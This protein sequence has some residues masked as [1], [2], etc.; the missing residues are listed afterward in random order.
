MKDNKNIWLWGVLTLLL[1]ITFFPLTDVGFVTGDDFVYSIWPVKNIIKDS[2]QFARG[3]GRFY[4]IFT[5]WIYKI[6][7]LIDSSFYYHSML[8]LPHISVVLLFVFLIKRIFKNETIGLLSGFIFCMF[9]QI[10]GGH[11]STAAYPF[12]FTFSFTILIG[13]LHF[14]LTY[15]ETDKYKYLLISAFIFAIATLFYE[16]YLV[17]YI[18]VFIMLI[19]R[20]HISDLK[21]KKSIFRFSKEIFPYFIFGITYIITYFVYFKIHSGQYQGNSFSSDLN[22]AIFFKTMGSLTLFS[23]PL[24]SLLDYKF[25]LIEYS[26]QD[27]QTINLFTL[28]FKQASLSAFIKGGL[29]LMVFYWIGIKTDFKIKKSFM[30]SV[31]LVSAIFIA[32]P[33]LPLALSKKYTTFIPTTYVTTYFAYFGVVTLCLILLLF[34]IVQSKRTK[35]I[36]YIIMT[37]LGIGLFIGTV[38]TQNVNEKVCEDLN[39]A[40]KRI[41]LMRSLFSANLINQNSPIYLASFHESTS[42]FSKSIT[43]QSEPFS[44][45]ADQYGLKIKQYTEYHSFYNQYKDIDCDVY[46]VSFSQAFKT[47]DAYFTLLHLKGSQ[48]KPKNTENYGDSLCVGYLSA[49]KK[50]GVGIA[51]TSDCILKINDEPM[52]KN[53]TFYY[54][55]IHFLRKPEVCQFYI[56][57]G[58]LFPNTFMISNQ[59]FPNLPLQK[60]GRYPVK[61]EQHWVKFIR[62]KLERNKE[63]IDLV[64]LKAKLNGITY[65]KAMNNDAIW[66]LYNEYQ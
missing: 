59:L 39:V 53:G 35:W 43:R 52:I 40:E 1:F 16:S 49:Y 25:F 48:L 31:G 13:S 27:L 58:N 9:F 36:Q 63:S 29:I 15:F 12:Y 45:F 44:A 66:I 28:V 2:I 37:F 46:I 50:F 60:L 55:N 56:K 57:G 42:Y 24:S 14:L 21:Y 20:Y 22:S 23:L 61:Y 3:T 62:K 11:S 51:G 38:I 5:L 32:L 34:L 26:K 33:H 10:V 18:L 8:I 19:K 47:G 54:Q 6:P 17:F 7:Y 4:F 64:K 30:G 41:T 65:D